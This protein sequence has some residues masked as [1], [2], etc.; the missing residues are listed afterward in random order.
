M[1]DA[2]GRL[3]SAATAVV[4]QPQFIF[5]LNKAV[6]YSHLMDVC[7]YLIKALF[8]HVFGELCDRV[9]VRVCRDSR[10]GESAAAAAA[11]A[12]FCVLRQ[13]SRSD[14]ARA[15]PHRRCVRFGVCML[16]HS[17]CTEQRAPNRSEY[18]FMVYFSLQ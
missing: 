1:A 8:A 9:R 15:M 17:V 5:R 3:L 11:A 10:V 2:R 7:E 16:S 13:R 12:V 6:V 18:T 4:G 14:S